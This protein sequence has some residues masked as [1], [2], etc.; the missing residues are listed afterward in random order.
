MSRRPPSR[1]LTHVAAEAALSI[2]DR[3]PMR[4]AAVAEARLCDWCPTPI[5]QFVVF[6]E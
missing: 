2:D 6:E 1:Q 4:L 3:D 5:R